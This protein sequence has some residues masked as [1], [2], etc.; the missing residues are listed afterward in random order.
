[1]TLASLQ[2]G[3][4]IA[5]DAL[6]TSRV[7]S[8]LTILSIVIGVASVVAMAALIGGIRASVLEQVQALGPE[9]FI[10][11]RWDQ[12]AVQV[13]NSGQNDPWEGTPRITRAD[14]AAIRGVAS[15]GSVTLSLQASADVRSG[16]TTLEALK[17]EGAAANWTRYSHGEL[18]A[19]RTF[20]PSE[21]DRSVPVAVLSA[22]AATALFDSPEAALRT[23]IR[24]ADAR[25]TVV[26]V[27]RKTQ[28]PFSAPEATKWASVPHTAASKYLRVD[29]V[30]TR[31]LVVPA[32][33]A[34]QSRAMD[35]VIA[36]LRTARGLAPGTDN[37][38]AVIRQEAF[39]DTFDQMTGVFFVVMI[40]LASLGLIVG[41]VG[42]VAI[43]MIAMQE[44]TREIG[45][46]KALG[47]T[48]SEI[49]WQ[50]LVESTTV[51]VIGGF[52][53]LGLGAAAALLLSVFTPLPVT[54]P[55]WSVAAALLTSA[56]TGIGFGLYPARRAAR[57]DPVE[58][59]RY[60]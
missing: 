9:N 41:G 30:H 14:V 59:L 27:Y 60:E 55:L 35:D 53:G 23:R 6:R 25:F 31:L 20:L 8:M 51:T 43:M 33:A 21:V 15:V 48:K 37:D 1:M 24:L 40:V 4:Q 46:R 28:N 12:S 29:P 47:A 16:G 5:F 54:I 38:F 19:G 22:D 26:G 32:A 42:V 7:R 58:A 39:V 10:V 17:V 57:L 36:A 18:I 56:V 45:L 34:T 49:L 13:L 52:L 44:R 11:A 3:I 50:F 2:E